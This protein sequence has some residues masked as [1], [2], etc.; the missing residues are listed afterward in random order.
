[1]MSAIGAEGLSLVCS[2]PA[3]EGLLKMDQS[4]MPLGPDLSSSV[5]YQAVEDL[6]IKLDV[7]GT[8]KEISGA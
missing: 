5:A 4:G 6:M 8:S 1:M 3:D 2:I 7:A